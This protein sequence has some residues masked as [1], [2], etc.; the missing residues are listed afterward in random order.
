MIR[1]WGQPKF[2]VPTGK[3]AGY[4]LFLRER[5]TR[6]GEWHLP[7]DF[8]AFAV[9]DFDELLRATLATLPQDLQLVSLNLDQEQ[10]VDP[11]Y[12]A[13]LGRWHQSGG[14]QLIIELTERM[15]V[16]ANQVTPV[17]LVEAARIY[18][19]AGLRVCVDDVGTGAN[20]PELVDVLDP[21][22]TEYKYALQNV[23]GTV[24]VGVIR[25][26]VAYWSQRAHRQHH[27]FALEGC[28]GVADLT[29]IHDF[30]P[31]LVQ[32]YFFGR[33]HPLTIAADLFI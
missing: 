30:A 24:N 13:Q 15:G 21:V 25:A 9:R 20:Q 12:V 22:V 33:P 10:F 18:Q 11:D 17:R 2:S 32:G 3:L 23:R 6:E 14:P 5:P 29:L 1:F 27:Q 16:G 31:D 7:A 28:E 4:E 26:Q 8:G 19:E